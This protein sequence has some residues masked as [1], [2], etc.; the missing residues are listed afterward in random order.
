MGTVA[1][2][3]R[4]E[5]D[6][7]VGVIRRAMCKGLD[8][9]DLGQSNDALGDFLGALSGLLERSALGKRVGTDQLRLVVG[10]NPVAAYKMIKTESGEKCHDANQKNRAPVG[11]RPMQHSQIQNFHRMQETLGVGFFF[12]AVQLKEA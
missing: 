12:A 2:A 3:S 11:Q 7:K 8:K 1:L 9:S 6:E 5:H 10:G 4:D